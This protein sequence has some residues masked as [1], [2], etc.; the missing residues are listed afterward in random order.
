MKYDLKLKGYVG[1]Y[2]FDADYVDYVLS[3]KEGQE[4][5]VL[6]D[7]LGGSVATALSIAAAFKMHGKV[8]VHFVGMNASAATVAS[9]GAA[10]ISIDSCAMYLVHKA[11]NLVFE[12]DYMNADKMQELIDRC[13]KAKTDLEKIDGNIAEM[14]AGKCK[15]PAEDLLALMKVG[16]WLTA[17]EAKEW[18]FVDE[19]TEGEEAPVLTNSMV[20]SMSKAG[21]PIPEGVKCE[22][23]EEGILAKIRTFFTQLFGVPTTENQEEQKPKKNIVMKIFELLAAVLAV[24]SFNFKEGK[25][26]MTEDQLKAIETELANNK[27]TIDGLN[28]TVTAK[29]TQIQDLQTQIE[30]LKNNPG[31]TTT[32]VLEDGKPEQEAT[33]FDV[34][35]DAAKLYNEVV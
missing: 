33:Y 19:I 9:M 16:G 21:I 5:N 10:H 7:S 18:G 28:N 26:E 1:G 13:K 14:Y 4:V 12:I 24:E 31:G 25:T 3:K 22:K 15:K 20:A 35:E 8:N 32:H 11:S 17:K 23:N 6:I 2:D 29:D 30:N 34:L 27:K